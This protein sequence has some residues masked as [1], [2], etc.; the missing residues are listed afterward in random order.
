[1]GCNWSSGPKEDAAASEAAAREKKQQQQRDRE[2]ANAALNAPKMD[3]KDFML[4][5]LK[6]QTIVK[7]P[8]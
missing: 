2:A 5:G 8:G 4:I 6:D 7:E 1:M 3:P